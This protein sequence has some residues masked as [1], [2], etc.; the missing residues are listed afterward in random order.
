MNTPKI[1]VI[2]I[3]LDYVLTGLRCGAYAIAWLILGSYTSES[4]I[5]FAAG[6]A[7]IELAYQ[8]YK[9]ISRKLR[10]HGIE[11]HL[12][13]YKLVGS[14]VIQCSKEETMAQLG[15][16]AEQIRQKAL[17]MEASLT[18]APFYKHKHV[19]PVCLT[20]AWT[21]AS[22]KDGPI[23]PWDI[24]IRI[25]S[26]GEERRKSFGSWEE[27]EAEFDKF[28]TAFRKANGLIDEATKTPTLH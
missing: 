20:A 21:G 28:E 18:Q 13:F 17:S 19:G 27:A 3:N 4:A 10:N 25:D 7:V 5:A 12:N 9:A 15:E 26:I 6:G 8:S 23:E 14:K 24:A 1:S 2:K 11:K 16:V 22:R